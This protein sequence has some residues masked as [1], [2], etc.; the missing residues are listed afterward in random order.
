MIGIDDAV[1]AGLQIGN[2]LIDRLWPDPA[3][4]AQA[5]LQLLQMQQSGE[6]AQLA[7]DTDLAK[8]QMA[9]NQT[10][11]ANAS[12]FVAGWRPAVGWCCA[13]GVGTQFLIAP[14][15]TWL[16]ALAGKPIAFP[17]L[18]M[19]TLIP[20]MAGMLGIGG[21]RTYEKVKGVTR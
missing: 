1:A 9:I 12:V 14:L 4:A 13:L 19:G 11:A 5:K 8:G 3:Q 15:A 6:L 17:Q 20:L 18:D 21:M 2:K 7:A 16:A 10:E